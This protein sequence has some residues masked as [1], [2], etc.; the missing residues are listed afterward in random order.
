MISSLSKHTVCFTIE[1]LFCYLSTTSFHSMVSS[2]FWETRNTVT[3]AVNSQSDC[4]CL[5][6][7]ISDSTKRCVHVC[8]AFITSHFGSLNLSQLFPLGRYKFLTLSS[9]TAVYNAID[10]TKWVTHQLLPCYFP[11]SYLRLNCK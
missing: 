4:L 7:V 2:I 3:D 1:V 11:G 5:N 10:L 8:S 6:I 9:A